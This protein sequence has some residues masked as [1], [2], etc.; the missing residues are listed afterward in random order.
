MKTFQK[1]MGVVLSAAMLLS[2][3]A[4][5]GSTGSKDETKSDGGATGTSKT[6]KIG[7]IGPLT[8]GTANYGNSVRQ[9]AELAVKEINAAGGVNGLTFELDF[10]DSAGDAAQAVQAYNKLLDNGMNVS[11]GAVLSGETAQVA[12]AG[13]DDGLLMITPSGSALSAIEGNDCAFRVCFNDPAQ[14]KAAAEYLTKTK[15][16]TKIAVFYAS[17]NDYCTGLFKTFKEQAEKSGLEIVTEQAFTAGTNTDFSAQISQINASGADLVFM[18][19]YAEDAAKFLTQAQGKLPNVK[20]YFGADGL[21][22]ILGKIDKVE[23]AENVLMLTPFAADDPAEN[24]QAF[25]KAYKEAYNATPDQFAADGYDAV[26]TIKEALLKANV[27]PSAKD[28]NEKMVAA[29]TQIT[30]NGVTGTMTWTADGETQK[31]AKAMIIHDGVATLF[32][33]K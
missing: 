17:D 26:Y 2:L 14:G 1:V 7:G 15:V 5:G 33:G 18:P 23:K 12:T 32:E 20:Y 13:K 4:C 16:A 25:V 31:D 8:G 27:D 9:G 28:F 19:I 21:D 22:G 30:V 3:T 29:M 11:L 24:V 6:L 10:Q